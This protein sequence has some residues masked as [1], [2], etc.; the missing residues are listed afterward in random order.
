MAYSAPV[1]KVEVALEATPLDDFEAIATWTDLSARVRGFDMKRGRSDQ[2]ATFTTGTATIVLDNSDRELDP[3]NA[4]GLVYVGDAKGLPFCPVRLTVDYKGSSYP[5]MARAY[6]GSEGWPGQRSPYG[7]E[8]TVTLNVVD[9]TGLFAWLGMPS[10]YWRAI[11]GQINPDWWLPGQVVDPATTADGFRVL[12]AS[13]TGGWATT[14][15]ANTRT[16]TDG[17]LNT[18]TSLVS[19]SASFTSADVGRA[20]AGSGIT[21]GTTIDSVS[22]T[23]TV[24]LSD[25]TTATAT[26]VTVLIGTNVEAPIYP[27][28]PLTFFDEQGSSEIKGTSGYN[29]TT[30]TQFPAASWVM[31]PFVS[32]VSDESDVFPAGDVTDLTVSFMWR[33]ARY[34]DGSLA[35]SAESDL[36]RIEGTDVHLRLF[37]DGLDGG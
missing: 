35:G 10:S 30:L 32:L 36:F 25:A 33:S 31:S 4:D 37:I 6:L 2:L 17:V 18:N 13:G 34:D 1:L 29:I 5:L 9:A 16:V 24:V 21:V 3:Q 8:A 27:F 28:F 26:G 22:N 20:V 23:T 19:A 7:T 12:N 14:Y 11:V 15:A